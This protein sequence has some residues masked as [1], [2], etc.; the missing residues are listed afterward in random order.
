[1]YFGSNDQ[2]L[3]NITA[4]YD[5]LKKITSLMEIEDIRKKAIL[6]VPVIVQHF[7]ILNWQSIRFLTIL[8]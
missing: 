8:K 2:R 3:R 1:M 4:D 5:N 7:V 6:V